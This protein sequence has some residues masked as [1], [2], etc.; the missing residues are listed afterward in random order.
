VQLD[1]GH[2]V[3]VGQVAVTSRNKLHVRVALAY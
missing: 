3:H 1:Y 2:G